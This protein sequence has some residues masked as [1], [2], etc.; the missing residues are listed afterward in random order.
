MWHSV[1]ERMIGGRKNPFKVEEMQMKTLEQPMAN[2]ECGFYIMWAVLYYLGGRSSHVDT[3][4][5]ML[6]ISFISVN[7]TK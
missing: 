5:C 1:Q 4:V 6:P 7:S 3:L 2:N